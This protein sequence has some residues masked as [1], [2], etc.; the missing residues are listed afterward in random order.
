M[1]KKLFIIDA[2]NI[3]Y[4]SYFG[5]TKKK[6][7]FSSNGLETSAIMGFVNT[8]LSI[9]N[10]EKPTH[11][12]VVFDNNQKKSFRY[13]EYPLYKNNRLKTPKTIKD[14]I[15]YI[16]KILYGLKI[17]MIYKEGYEADDIIGTIAKKVEN[18][19][20]KVYIVSQDKD[21]VQLV[22]K[23]IKIY[24]LAIKGNQNE[25]LGVS[26]VCKKY[27]IK[28]PIQFIDLF[29]MIG[30]K[31]DNIPGLPGIGIKKS[32]II[33]KKYGSI[34]NLFK[35]IDEIKNI[36]KNN[37][38]DYK[39]L[40]SISKKLITIITD[41]PIIFNEEKMMITYPDFYLIENIF[42]K[43][44]FKNILNKTYKIFDYYK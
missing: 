17:E 12:I 16:Y 43:L 22:S 38:Y 20:Y 5:I 41:V 39:Y 36:K 8:L 29:S 10:K 40:G 9:I 21:F 31:S 35:N 19:K 7:F 14:S 18:K 23:N 11:A 44:N 26:E 34:E 4:K 28:N 37:I 13:K 33:L 42:N 2:Y 24:K 30:D 1:K 27:E 32:K 15:P 6:S 25:I 3:I